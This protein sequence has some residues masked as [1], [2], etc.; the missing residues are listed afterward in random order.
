MGVPAVMQQDLWHFCST[1][2]KV[3]FLAWHSGFKDPALPQLRPK[4]KKKKETENKSRY[5]TMN[6]AHLW[7]VGHLLKGSKRRVF[8]S[9]WLWGMGWMED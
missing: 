8:A 2:R 7:Y 9:R 1:R 6:M 3:L 5:R 4:E